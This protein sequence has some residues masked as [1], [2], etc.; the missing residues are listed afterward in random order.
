MLLFNEHEASAATVVQL[1]MVK[2]M[3]L[4][5]K[6]QL[7]NFQSLSRFQLYCRF[8]CYIFCFSNSQMHMVKTN[9]QYSWKLK[10]SPGQCNS[11]NWKKKESIFCEQTIQLIPNNSEKKTSSMFTHL[12]TAFI[13]IYCTLRGRIKAKKCA[14]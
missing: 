5:C 10:R 2:K 1:C 9:S 3:E 14:V 4:Q 8:W 12:C 6:I 7:Y 13:I 11:T